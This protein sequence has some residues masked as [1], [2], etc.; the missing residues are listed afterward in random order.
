MY[1]KSDMKYWWKHIERNLDMSTVWVTVRQIR[2]IGNG[3]NRKLSS[4]LL[5]LKLSKEKLKSCNLPSL[6]NQKGITCETAVGAKQDRAKGN[7]QKA[8]Y[9]NQE[10]MYE[11]SDMKYWWKHI[12]RNLD[13]STVWVTVRQIRL[14]GN[15]RNRKLSSELLKL[16]LSKEKLKSCNLPSLRNQK[17]VTCGTAAGAKQERTKR[18]HQKSQLPWIWK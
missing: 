8:Y 4:E 7:L 2:L 6:R 1:E 10:R 15:G 14:I 18:N 5:K 11:K 3:R 16:K 12:E 9:H 13:M 17:G